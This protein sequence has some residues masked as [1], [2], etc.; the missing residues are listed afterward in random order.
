MTAPSPDQGAPRLLLK[1]RRATQLD[2]VAELID[3]RSEPMAALPLLGRVSAGQPLEAIEDPDWINVP[4]R[5]IQRAQFALRVRGDSM[6]EDQIEDGDLILIA[7]QASAANGEIVVAL[8][9]G[10][11]AT[12]KRFYREPH[13]IRLQPAHAE[14]PPL[15]VPAEAVHL[16]GV[17][18]AV[19]RELAT[20]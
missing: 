5:L 19:L 16:L 7:P 8:I 13:H 6:T 9:D 2:A 11:Q 17:V 10:E 3:P 14:M 12:L 20:D 4:E 15:R 1:H 18:T